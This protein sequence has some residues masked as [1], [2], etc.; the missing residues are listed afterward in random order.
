MGR[1]FALT[2]ESSFR[3]IKLTD[4]FF[5][6]LYPTVCACNVGGLGRFQDTTK[7][8]TNEMPAL[9]S[10]HEGQ[11]IS[12]RWLLSTRLRSSSFSIQ[13]KLTDQTYQ[14]TDKSRVEAFN[15]FITKQ[16]SFPE[17]AFF[18]CRI[19]FPPFFNLKIANSFDL[20]K[21]LRD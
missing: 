21:K 4:S 18:N 8:C 6:L 9:S 10:Y 5:H 3:L 1:Q 20:T 2:K 17:I 11:T 7:N 14:I 13:L 12:H 19:C 15:F 16:K